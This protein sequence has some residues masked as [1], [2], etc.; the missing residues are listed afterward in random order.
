MLR[1]FAAT[2]MGLASVA[3]LATAAA[4]LPGATSTAGLPAADTLP[5][6]PIHG[7][8]SGVEFDKYGWHYSRRHSCTRMPSYAPGPGYTGPLTR[9]PVCIQECKF[10][11]P[12]KT[13]RAVCR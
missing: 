10:V 3:I 12:V 1:T 2:V 11:G 4:A 5:V 7:C 6:V 8:H 13:C 9:G